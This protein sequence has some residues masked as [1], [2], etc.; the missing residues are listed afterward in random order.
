MFPFGLAKQ[1]D[2]FDPLGE[3]IPVNCSSPLYQH[4]LTSFYD[5][6]SPAEQTPKC[7]LQEVSN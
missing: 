5:Q 1:P 2:F 7:S 4:C 3:D 6:D